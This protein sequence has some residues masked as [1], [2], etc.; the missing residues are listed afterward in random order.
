MHVSNKLL[1]RCKAI[2]EVGFGVL[3]WAVLGA[4]VGGTAA[5]FFGVLFGTLAG[6][7]HGDIWLFASAGLYFALRGALAGALVGGFARMIDPE[8]VADLT[9][10]SRQGTG[11]RQ[12]DLSRPSA[13]RHPP[14]S[15]WRIRKVWSTEGFSRLN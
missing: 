9:S 3:G 15:Q 1:T 7:T 5:W 2:R 14:I 13:L 12:V 10:R 4:T 8:G 11:Q 6:L